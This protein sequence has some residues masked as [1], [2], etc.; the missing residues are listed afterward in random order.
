MIWCSRNYNDVKVKAF[1]IDLIAPVRIFNEYFGSG[2]SSIVFQ[3]IRESKALYS[4][5]A[6]F[7]TPSK[8]E[9][10]HYVTAYLNTS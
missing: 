9:K 8:L 7:S 2:L 4:A 10:S 3:E 5:R 1:D 6:Y